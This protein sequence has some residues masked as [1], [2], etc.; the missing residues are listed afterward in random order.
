MIGRAA[1]VLGA[2]GVAAIAALGLGID[3]AGSRPDV[4]AP[5]AAGLSAKDLRGIPAPDRAITLA[6]KRWLRLTR[7]PV[8]SLRSLGG[9]HPG[10]KS[11]RVNRS[12]ARLTRRDGRQRF[13]YP[14]KTV[15]VK[16]GTVGTTVTLVAIMRRVT[17][18]PK[19]SAWRYVEYTRRRAGEAFRR[20]G[21]G[22]SLCSGCHV[23]ATTTQRS[24]YVFSR[25]KPR[26]R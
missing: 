2:I 1:G 5:R 21:G 16:T 11:I 6:S 15:V 13:P 22:Q 12:R 17:T 3:S 20:V 25:L 8:A 19:P 14:R 23:S 24:D 9:A 4:P 18:G 7:R 26:P 10:A